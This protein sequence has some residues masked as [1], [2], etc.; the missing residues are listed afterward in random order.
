MPSTLLVHG[1]QVAEADVERIAASGAAVVLCPRSNVRLGVGLPPVEL[2]RRHNVPLALGTDSLASCDSLSVW[3]EIAFVRERFVA[4]LSPAEILD[5][6]TRGGARALGLEG[7]MGELAPGRGAHF[8]VI[9]PKGLPA[10][11]ELEEFLCS[12]GCTA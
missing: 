7:E 4:I 8:Q 3:D 5:I 10:A 12:S 6:A 2:Y 9:A 1:V 11:S